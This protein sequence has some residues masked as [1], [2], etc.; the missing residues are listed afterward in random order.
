[1]RAIVCEQYGSPELLTLKELPAPPLQPEQVRVKVKTA[2]VNFV[3]SLFVAGT[4]QIKIPTPFTPGGDIAGEVIEVGEAVADWSVGDRVLASPGI[5]GFAE[6]VVL[7]ADQLMA[8]PDVM[9]HEAASTFMQAN[10]TAY[11]GLV[12]R[13]HLQAGETLL[14]LGAAGGTGMAA[15]HIAKALGATVIA[16]ASSEAK[17]DACRAAGADHCINYLE[18][19]LKVQ[20]KQLSGGSGV[21]MVFDP[22][23]GDYSEL[24]LRACAPDARFLV[25]GF[26]AGDIPRI[27]LNLVLLK[28]CQ[29]VGVDW[30]G[31][32]MLRPALFDE[33]AK[34]IIAL[35]LSGKLPD[36]PFQHFA[37]AETPEALATMQRRQLVGRAVIRVDE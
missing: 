13:G 21:D 15:I 14:V 17:L 26:A 19:D 18:E 8:I 3:D 33:V 11:F 1:M 6:Q 30:G 2:G 31:S 10:A 27:P 32:V 22:I 25:V 9:S 23:G 12:N 7:Q 28:K 37:L 4:Y 5:G 36:P 16:A 35:Y 29:I 20:A 24:A 34:Q